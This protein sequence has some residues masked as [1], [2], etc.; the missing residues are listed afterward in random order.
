M[1]AEYDGIIGAFS[2]AFR[3]STSRLFK[4]YVLVS[5]IATTGIGIFIVIALVVLIGQTAS[6]QGGSLTLSRAFYVVVGLFIVLP[7]VAPTLAIA[8]RHRQGITASKRL[9]A[10]V[11]VAGFVFLLSLY[12]GVVASMPATF[13]IDGETVTRPPASGTG[14]F[15][16]L[17][18]GLYAVPAG[19]SWTV[20][21][22]GASC[23]AGTY[24]LFR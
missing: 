7:A 23:I 6:I 5:G 4:L 21:L 11:A 1:A 14:V 19:L 9:E 12:L 16:P 10:A 13:N 18:T 22:V 17:I 3:T 20:P 2:Y 15:E 24:W 8:R